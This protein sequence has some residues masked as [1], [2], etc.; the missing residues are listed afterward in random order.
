M[1]VDNCRDCFDLDN[2]LAKA[3]EIGLEK[4]GQQTSL[5]THLE[6]GLSNK[7]NFL[8][9]EFYLQAFLI[10]R[11]GKSKAFLVVYLKAGTDYPVALILVNDVNHI[12]KYSRSFA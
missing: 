6:L 2:D 9:P 1:G 5:V 10:N 7:R 12:K 11:F 3:N 8:E 4:L